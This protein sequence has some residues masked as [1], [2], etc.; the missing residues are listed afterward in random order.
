MNQTRASSL[1]LL[2]LGLAACGSG[3]QAPAA[4]TAPPTVAA[5]PAAPPPAPP[6]PAP[7]SPPAPEV[8][9]FLQPSALPFHLPPFDKIKD[10][11]YAPAFEAGMAEQ[12]KESDTIAR[13]SD[14]PTFDNTIVALERTGR[15][16]TRVQKAFSNLNASNTDDAMEKVEAEMAPKLAAH[17]DAILLDAALFARVDAVYQRRGELG[18]DPESA[19]LVERY[20]DTFVRAGARL[21]EAD[22]ATLKK[23]NEELSSLSTRFRQNVLAATKDGAVVVDDVHQLDGLSQ[24]QIG[25]AAEAAKAR[26]LDGQWVIGLQNTTIQPPL[27][28][29]KNRALRERVFRASVM[30]GRGGA[31]DNTGVVSR[32]VELRAKK[33]ALLGYPN[34]AAYA[35]SEETAGTPAAVNRILDQLAPV[36]LTKAREEAAGIQAQIRAD[37]R[38]AHSSPFTLA[39]WDWAFYAQ[40]VRKVRFSFD[41]AQVKPYFEMNRVLQDGVFFAA[42]ELY[43]ITFTERHDLPVY[44]PDVRVFEVRDAD[45]ST[46]GLLLLDYFKR[47]SKQGGAWMD[48]FVDQSTLLGDKPV[49]INN[50]NVPRPAP[51]APALL[52]FDDVT[53]M[54]HEFGHGLHGLLS[55][56]KYPLLSGAGVPPDFAEF[57]SQFNEM[58]SREPAVLAHFAKHYQT[59]E[60][61]PRALLDKILAAKDYGQGYATLEY[62]AASL[63]DQSWHQIPLASVPPAARVMAFEDAALARHRVAYPPVPPRYHTTYFSHVFAGGYEAGYYA[64]IW[65]EVLARDAGA[66]FHAHGGL[67]RAAGDTFRARILSRGR[68][69]EPSVLFEEFYGHPPDIK[70]LLEYRGLTLPGQP[71]H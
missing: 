66:W 28:Q 70:P 55:A 15:T 41:D 50:L 16:L 8:N 26:G 63:V 29:M 46:I 64:Y 21:S 57:P 51:G 37:A 19:Q 22:K 4:A 45:G 6:P 36:A 61:L 54:F 34:F 62:L 13:D 1:V 33:A 56:V 14:P 40:Q 12:R 20:E 69:K 60:P 27:A 11:D 23:L 35:L 3:A 38:A 10:A 53:G 59:G 71:K 43:G 67:S 17:Q 39:P 18:L 58:W 52:T 7:P 2:A 24:E 48:T 32:I 49:V 31:T 42:H 65:S 68:T 47:D 9:P 25:A 5:A 30:R 44:Q